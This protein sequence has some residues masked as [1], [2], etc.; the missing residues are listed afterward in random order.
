MNRW[1]LLAL[2]CVG[3]VTVPTDLLSRAEQSR[4]NGELVQALRMLDAVPITHPRYPEARARALGVE[5]QLRKSQELLLQGMYLRT[6]W[7]DEEAIDA[8]TRARAVWQQLPGV[9]ELILAT[10]SRQQ[11]FGPRDVAATPLAT[12]PPTI[13]PLPPPSAQPSTPPKTE[14]PAASPSPAP[15]PVAAPAPAPV[16]VVEPIAPSAGPLRPSLP[17]VEPQPAPAP[18]QSGPASPPLPIV[19]A[20]PAV[21]L[22]PPALPAGEIRSESTAPAPQTPAADAGPTAVAGPGDGDEVAVGLAGIETRLLR[23]EIDI[24]VQDLQA[25]QRA[26]ARDPRVRTR[27]ARVLHQRALMRYGRGDVDGAAADWQRVIELDPAFEA[28]RRLLPQAEAEL[29]PQ[30]ASRRD[31]AGG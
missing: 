30:R 9:D 15:S 25:L 5:Q 11:V 31:K 6:E 22:P 29:T 10:R 21:E 1:S 7:R 14:A 12:A 20:A 13:A 24:A 4:R 26:H 27:M 16:A 23:G 8:F 18:D 19:M 2:L 3:C 28:A 17:A